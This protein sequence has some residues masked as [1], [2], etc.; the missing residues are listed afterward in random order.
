MTR[1]ISVLPF[2]LIGCNESSTETEETPTTTVESEVSDPVESE[3]EDIQSENENEESG[4]SMYLLEPEVP[5][6]ASA[7]YST[8]VGTGESLV[9]ISRYSGLSVDEIG[10]YNQLDVTAT[11]YPGQML[12]LPFEDEA[13]VEMFR[14]ARAVGTQDRLDAYLSSRGGLVDIDEHVVRTGESA[15]GIAQGQ[16]GLPLWV[17]SSFNEDLDLDYIGIG[18]R[19]SVPVL[20]DTLASLEEEEVDS[21]DMETISLPID[22]E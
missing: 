3:E 22:Y 9:L 20:G 6:E 17:L 13:Q 19:L 8:R 15:W 10:D 14:S 1:Y 12:E 11:I 16:N 7:A 18:Q 4:A 2:L 5:E 21:I